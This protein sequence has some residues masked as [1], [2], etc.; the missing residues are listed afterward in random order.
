[1]KSLLGLC[2]TGAIIK[3]DLDSPAFEWAATLMVRA[4]GSR[5]RN[6]LVEIEAEVL[7]EFERIIFGSGSIGKQNPVAIWVCLWLLIL[8]YKSL[9]PWVDVI[10]HDDIT[11]KSK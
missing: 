11:G 1:M 2:Q 7:F 4:L 10:W 5:V 9:T 8:H 6:A 3:S